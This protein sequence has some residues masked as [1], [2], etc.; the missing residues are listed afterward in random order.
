MCHR[1]AT[2]G[3]NNDSGMMPVVFSLG[4]GNGGI[5]II[6]G[7]GRVQD[8]MAVVLDVGPL[9]AARCRLPAVEE[10]DEHGATFAD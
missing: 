3:A 4:N 9:Y 8:L 2:A 6:V 7:Q 5:E 1:P 10:E